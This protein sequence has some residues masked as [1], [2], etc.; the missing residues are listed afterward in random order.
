[1][2]PQYKCL[3]VEGQ[4]AKKS[5]RKGFLN[6]TQ[7]TVSHPHQRVHT[8]TCDRCLTKAGGTVSLALI[9]PQ[10]CR[11]SF[12]RVLCLHNSQVR[13]YIPTTPAQALTAHCPQVMLVAADG[14]HSEGVVCAGA[15]TVTHKK[16]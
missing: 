1:M 2:R 13:P 15:V 3:K 4:L 5:R 10:L 7:Q 8:R 6:R 11:M 9:P 16:N 12:P 14:L